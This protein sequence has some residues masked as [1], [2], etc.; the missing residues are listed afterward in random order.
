MQSKHQ[1][2]KEIYERATGKPYIEANL[3]KK[4]TLIKQ[5][6][7]LV[8]HLLNTECL[9]T[10]TRILTINALKK[11]IAKQTGLWEVIMPF[12]GTLGAGGNLPN[13]LTQDNSNILSNG[14]GILI[15][16]NVFLELI[17][18]TTIFQDFQ[19]LC[20][21]N[22]PDIFENQ[23]QKSYHFESFDAIDSIKADMI[24]ILQ[25]QGF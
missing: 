21:F 17:E 14:T 11:E 12:Y 23:Y 22:E 10:P 19:I 15:L 7:K 25:K 24:Y 20:F 2:R 16:G 3:V 4:G 5:C 18:T 6:I 9:K 13:Y 1:R 8:P